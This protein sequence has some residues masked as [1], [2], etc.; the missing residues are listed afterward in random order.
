MNISIIGNKYKMFDIDN[1]DQHIRLVNVSDADLII[2][3]TDRNLNQ[4]LKKINVGVPI[5]VFVDFKNTTLNLNKLDDNII[6]MIFNEHFIISKSNYDDTIKQ[7]IR[8][9]H[10]EM[11]THIKKVE[12]VSK[13]T[14]HDIISI[15]KKIK[16]LTKNKNDLIRNIFL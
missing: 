9:A 7:F 5:I 3:Q 13:E 1:Y 15:Y 11:M 12:V 8:F 16:N 10:Y 2:I 6:V 4:I 14:I